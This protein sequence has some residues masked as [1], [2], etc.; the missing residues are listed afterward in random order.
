LSCRASRIR[1]AAPANEVT[2][3]PI[4][5]YDVSPRRLK[6]NLPIT[7]PTIPSTLSVIALWRPFINIPAGRPA[8]EQSSQQTHQHVASLARTLLAVGRDFPQ[9]KLF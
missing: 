1:I 3:D 4:T 9:I 8:D 5:F 6:R 2:T 7:P